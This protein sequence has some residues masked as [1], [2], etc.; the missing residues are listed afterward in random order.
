M[1]HSRKERLLAHAAQR[2]RDYPEY[3][4]WVLTRYVEQER[5]SAEILAQRLG[6]GSHD[7]PRLEL[8]LRPRAEH[9]ADDIGQISAKFNLDP[10]ALATIVRLV[11]SVEALATGN[12][13]RAVTDSGWLMAARARKPP[14]PPADGEGGDHDRSGS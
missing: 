8:C 13:D 6:I 9:F 4:G 2:A 14:R 7:L 10:T 3:L 11:E 1:T 12:A 5:I